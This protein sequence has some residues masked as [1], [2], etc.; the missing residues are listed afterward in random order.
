MLGSV[1]QNYRL[2]RR[3]VTGARKSKLLTDA[4]TKIEASGGAG[5]CFYQNNKTQAYSR[6]SHHCISASHRNY[7]LWGSH[8]HTHTFIQA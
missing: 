4:Q 2:G 1:G 8:T 5:A 7:L 3:D 6:C